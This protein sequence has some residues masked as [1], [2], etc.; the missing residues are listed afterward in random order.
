M[1]SSVLWQSYQLASYTQIAVGRLYQQLEPPPQPA[2]CCLLQLRQLRPLR[3]L[4][5][6]RTGSILFSPPCIYP[7]FLRWEPRAEPLP[8]P[9]YRPELLPHHGL[10]SGADQHRF[11]NTPHTLCFSQLPTHSLFSWKAEL[12]ILQTPK[13]LFIQFLL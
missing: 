4:P 7:V 10:E 3:V 13:R 5:G 6:S 11:L 9:G 2:L 8:S 12:A 1:G